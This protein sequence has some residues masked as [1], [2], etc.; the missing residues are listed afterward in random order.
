M[1]NALLPLACT[2]EVSGLRSFQ[3][4]ILSRTKGLLGRDG[5]RAKSKVKADPKESEREPGDLANVRAVLILRGK[6]VAIQ[7]TVAGRGRTPVCVGRL[8]FREVLGWSIHQLPVLCTV[9]AGV[10]HTA[11]ALASSPHSQI[12]HGVPESK[13]G[14][15][16]KLLF[17]HHTA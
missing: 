12:R 16:S 15:I 7:E 11:P 17:T 1:S 4:P 8:L 2:G 13:G 10:K 3:E 5:L 6:S 14:N 9:A